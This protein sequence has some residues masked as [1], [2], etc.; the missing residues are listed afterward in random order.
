MGSVLYIK[1]SHCVCFSVWL[2]DTQSAKGAA[3]QLC[4]R[5]LA[6]SICIYIMAV[7]V[8]KRDT[9]RWETPRSVLVPAHPL[10]AMET[11]V[12]LGQVSHGLPLSSLLVSNDVSCFSPL[13]FLLGCLLEFSLH[14]QYQGVRRRKAR[15]E[16]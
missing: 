13:C 7:G 16:C 3:R 12:R 11:T 8:Q 14:G 9:E 10:V 1:S 5:F 6:T 4:G 2:Q 15:L